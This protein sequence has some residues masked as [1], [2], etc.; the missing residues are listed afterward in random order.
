MASDN[1]DNVDEIIEE[2]C[3]IECS[4]VGDLNE[5]MLCE[6]CVGM[7][8]FS[9]SRCSRSV[10]EP[11]NP[12]GVCNNCSIPPPPCSSCNHPISTKLD[13][14]NHHLCFRCFQH[15]NNGCVA[16]VKIIEKESIDQHNHDSFEQ[17]RVV[18]KDDVFVTVEGNVECITCAGSEENGYKLICDCAFRI[19]VSCR[20]NLRQ[21]T[22]PVCRFNLIQVDMPVP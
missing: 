13:G 4:V 8:T 15:S 19:C 10:T 16:C 12:F 17:S 20:P 14:C 7:T 21:E 5:F 2:L 6:E 11:A 3:C 22:C 1:I 18:L 9:C